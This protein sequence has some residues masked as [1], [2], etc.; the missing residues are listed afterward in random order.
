MRKIVYNISPLNPLKG[1]LVRA[2]LNL[3]HYVIAPFRGLGVKPHHIPQSSKVDFGYRIQPLNPLKGTLARAILNLLHHIIAPFRGLG[4]KSQLGVKLGVGGLFLLLLSSCS[5]N[6]TDLQDD[7]IVIQTAIENYTIPSMHANMDVEEDENEISNLYVFLFPTTASQ[8]LI[9]YYVDDATFTGGEWSD[10]TGN[11]SLDLTQAEAGNRNVHL[12]ANCANIKTA[13]DTVTVPQGLEDMVFNTPQPW[14]D[15]LST[16]ILM[17]GYG[18]HNFISNPVLSTINLERALAKL[19]LIIKIGE[20]FQ[21]IPTVTAGK[22]EEYQYQY[23]NFDKQTYLIEPDSKTND[24]ASSAWLNWAAADAT[25]TSGKVSEL[26]LVTYLNESKNAGA[27]IDLQLPFVWEGMLPPPE[28]GDENYK[29]FL[30]EEIKR[31][32]WYV[33]DV[34]ISM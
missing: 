24:L 14:S 15:D 13:L 6:T 11:I 25:L 1:T 19:E 8:S 21:A 16:P 29:L 30:P 31:N 5:I 3:L 12:I 26:R 32:H 17:Y 10:A 18:N 7:G 4:V 20:K 27:G 34:E 2:I 33:F 28:F 23:I 9:K 22:L